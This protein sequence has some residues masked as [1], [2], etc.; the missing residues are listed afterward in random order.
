MKK[1]RNVSPFWMSLLLFASAVLFCWIFVLQYGI[2]G[3]KVDWLSQHSVLADY[4]RT[5]FYATGNLF[6]D[7]AWNLG[8]GQNI[9][10][11]SYYGLFGPQILLSYLLPFLPMDLYLMISNILIYGGTV[12]LFYRWLCNKKLDPG[13]CAGTAFL[14]ALGAPLLFHFYNQLMFVNYM[15][16]LCL[17]L[18][19][20][21]RH[22]DQKEGAL[23]FQRDGMLVAAVTGMLFTSYY[24]SIGG[25][26]ALGIY[27]LS[28]YGK[29]NVCIQA[30]RF[31]KD[32]FHFFLPLVLAVLLAGIL[33]VPTAASIASGR[34][35]GAP[36][37][38]TMTAAGFVKE[39]LLP[40]F[41]ALRF[42]YTP[43]G[44]GLSALSLVA[45]IDGLLLGKG[46]RERLFP[47]L[48]LF[49]LTMPL[50]GYLL[51]G[52]LYAKDKVFLPFLPL[53]CL[54]TALYLQNS[55][56]REKP[57]RRWEWLP[58]A[59]A[60]FLV[61]SARHQKNFG[62]YWGLVLLDIGLM[63][64]LFWQW[65]RRQGIPWPLVLSCVLLFGSG[66]VVNKTRDVMVPEKDYK[67]L[68]DASM[69]ETVS[70]TLKGTKEC[71][72]MEQ[73]GDG[74]MNLANINRV[75]DIRQNLSSVY[76]S[77]SN[78]AYDRFR[79]EK[80][81][82]HA[83]FRNV[84]MQNG[85]DNPCFLH[86]MGVKYLLT[87]HPIAGYEH[88][89][90]G[91]TNNLWQ[92]VEAAPLFYVTDQTVGEDA[93]E[94]LPFPESQTALLKAAAV[95]EE[96]DLAGQQRRDKQLLGQRDFARCVLQLPL[97]E[98]ENLSIVPLPE[99][100]EIAVKKKTK[101]QAEVTGGR[102]G[103]ELFAL[104]FAV[105]NLEP[106]QD[107]YIRVEEQTNRLTS[108]EHVYANHNT[109]FRYT[110][111]RATDRETVELLLGPGHYRL[112]DLQ[113]FT[114]NLPIE[115]EARLY[116][117]PMKTDPEGLL[118]YGGDGVTGTVRAGEGS[119]LITSI[120]YDEN[121]T[122]LIDG[123]QTETIPV[124]TAFLGAK[125]SPGTHRISVE[126]HA[127]GQKAG[128]AFSL[129]GLV[130]LGGCLLIRKYRG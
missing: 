73:Y 59:A 40:R 91:E 18:M 3:S 110:V 45:L 99:G 83:A 122:V 30:A 85:T 26:L 105:E 114:G 35:G 106:K 23:F 121:F 51:N 96:K 82:L 34:A 58:Y 117:R 1:M 78:Q 33:L 66:W 48:L 55:K 102:T 41:T 129:V 107:M 6:P 71:C 113:A 89:K 22:F 17:G 47:G 98:N 126:Y 124:N 75:L 103:D 29:R 46:W 70:H 127:P 44:I 87:D 36:V 24:F 31:F 7:F 5:R 38:S 53:L 67:K 60:C 43:Y 93:Y 109:L 54:Q 62:K 81:G 56:E 101:V 61:V 2:F 27:W 90:G 112:K 65:R 116:S 111:T 50:F 123:K 68:T 20:V 42:L 39:M 77:S 84:M 74:E 28:E 120:P 115:E 125:L 19:G 130:L 52:G 80:F 128:A 92:A 76:A 13:I 4:F 32:S 69:A 72:R 10:N 49:F 25:L 57:R 100:Y 94:K 95:P 14:F 15:P 21:D 12:V 88:Q 119:Y 64:F 9:Y 108:T 118:A 97:L 63:A 37:W 79:K 11:F 86:F 8:G 16:F 104:S